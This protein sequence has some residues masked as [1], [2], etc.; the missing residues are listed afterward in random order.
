MT[1]APEDPWQAFVAAPSR[2]RKSGR[3]LVRELS[4]RATL[5]LAVAAALLL[6]GAPA[7][8]LWAK[9]SPRVAVS[10]S[11]QG[12]EL[13]HP[14]SSEFFATEASFLIV[15]AVVGLVTGAAVW[16]FAR[17]RGVAVPVGIAVGALLAGAVARAVGGRVVVDERLAQVCRQASCDIYDGTL[18]VRSP[19]LVVVW[20]VAALAVFI[21]L[22]ALLDPGDETDDQP[23]GETD[24][25]GSTA[26]PWPAIDGSVWAP[27]SG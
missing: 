17:R 25:E 3:D 16:R 13:V 1:T 24:G 19:G 11:A 5:P 6:L 12:P 7:G 22:T 15:M 23:P 26:G 10:F 27:P 9:V 14:E 8:I 2:G 4:A 18:H 21:A 20:G